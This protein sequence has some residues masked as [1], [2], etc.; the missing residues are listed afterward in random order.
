MGKMP[1]LYKSEAVLVKGSLLPVYDGVHSA[2]VARLPNH[3]PVI[4]SEGGRVLVPLVP[5]VHVFK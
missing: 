5:S 1:Y 4:L 2:L 3:V